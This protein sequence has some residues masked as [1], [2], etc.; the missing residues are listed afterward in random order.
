MATPKKKPPVAAVGFTELDH[1][2]LAKSLIGLKEV[3]G[4]K[5]PI[6]TG[7]V[8]AG[9]AQIHKSLQDLVNQP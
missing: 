8:L 1:M 5:D 3:A 6:G 7:S 2:R 4:G 9:N